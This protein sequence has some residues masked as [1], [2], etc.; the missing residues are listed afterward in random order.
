MSTPVVAASAKILG[1]RNGIDSLDV[2]S[3]LAGLWSVILDR[4]EAYRRGFVRLAQ[5]KMRFQS[6]SIEPVRARSRGGGGSLLPVNS[7][8][9][10]NF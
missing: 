4:P 6:F 10:G 8:E 9:L 1:T 2:N 5:R 7:R 3:G